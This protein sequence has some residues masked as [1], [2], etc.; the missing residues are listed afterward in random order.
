MSFVYVYIFPCHFICRRQYH[1]TRT[2][3]SYVSYNKLKEIEYALGTDHLVILGRGGGLGFYL[4]KIFWFS[5]CKKKIKWLKRGT[6]K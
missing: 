6:K 1:R 3:Q 2:V 5:V 4:K